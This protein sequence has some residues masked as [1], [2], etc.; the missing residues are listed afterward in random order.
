MRQ[1]QS[2]SV[3]F[4]ENVSNYHFAPK[5]RFSTYRILDKGRFC[6][7]P[8]PSVPLRRALINFFLLSLDNM[9]TIP[10]ALIMKNKTIMIRNVPGDLHGQLR[11]MALKR[12]ISMNS[13]LIE[14]IRAVVQGNK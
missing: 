14:M 4:A 11:I 7:D 2:S 13:L 12:G 3:F 9:L 5:R 6:T 8:F 10:Y 1:Q